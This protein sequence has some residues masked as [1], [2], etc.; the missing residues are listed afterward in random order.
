MT[1]RIFRSVFLAG[2]VVL[3]LCCTLLLGAQYEYHERQ[4]FEGLAAE[5]DYVAHGMDLMGGDYLKTLETDERLTWIAADG[6]V[7]YDSAADAARM[8]NHLDREEVAQ[9]LAE[10]RGQ[11]THESG[12]LMEKTLYYAE[13]L[14]D[15]T[16]VRL[17]CTQE[18][19]AAVLLRMAGPLLWVVLLALGL[20]L[21]LAYRLARQIV[22]PI[23]RM[24]LGDPDVGSVYPELEPL[25][26]RVREQNRTIRRQMDELG[27]RQR[28]FEAI[29]N[30][31]R[32]GFLL[33]D[34]QLNI[35]SG[36]RSALQLLSSGAEVSSLRQSVCRGE[37]LSAATAALAGEHAEMLLTP[38][39]GTYQVVANPVVADG[40]VTGVVVIM[41]DVTERQEREALRREFTANVS[42]ELKTPLTSISGFAELM[43]EGLVPLEKMKEFSGDIYR[44]SSRL[45]ALVDDIIDLSRLDEG[46]APMERERVE[47]RAL[48]D[49][50]LESL[51]SP[52]EKKGVTLS[53]TGDEAWITGVRTLLGEMLYNLC[54]NAIKYNR[55]GGSVTVSVAK[56]ERETRL[57]VA[58]TGI[59]IPYAHQ[60]RVFE[61]FYRVDKSHSRAVGG[62]GLGLSI[63]KHAAQYHNARLELESEPGRGTAITVIFKE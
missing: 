51:R 4:V 7:L 6:T 59:G 27:K 25:V 14:A 29:T 20:S 33:V 26:G 57:C 12:T 32:E 1:G 30:N 38:E 13:R 55:E 46:S 22:R 53:L 45:I 34:R 43:K 23:N 48:A 11:S 3:V 62:T 52:A 17:S 24:D 2:L 41:M 39:S 63:V 40:Q 61:R 5:T 50:T 35:L 21:L 44:E 36:N 18:T 31:M 19:V 9:A 54:D 47:L 37:I 58:D 28:E 8:E 16:V 42:H 10:G 49:E 15:G 56:G 60:S